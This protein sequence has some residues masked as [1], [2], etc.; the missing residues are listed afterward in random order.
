MRAHVSFAVAIALAA[1]ACLAAGQN[2]RPVT[3]IV[4]GGIVVT[5]NATH[6]IFNPGAVAV[7]GANILAVGA[8]DAV[9]AQ[10]T[11]TDTIDV[12]DQVVLPGLI[13]T[14]THAPMV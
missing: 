8:P 10:Y 12:S 3:L 9:A 1:S 11:A 6:Q 4:T 5:E 7:D 14:H 2:R 13:N